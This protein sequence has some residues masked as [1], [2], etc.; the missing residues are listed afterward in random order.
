MKVCHL[1]SVHS[2]MDIRIF[3]KECQSLASEGY[4]VHLVAPNA[5][6]SIVKGINIHGVKNDEKKGR[7]NRMTKTVY[8]VYKKGLEI[9]ADIY[10]FHDPELIPVGIKL[11]KKGKKIIYDIH[12]DLPRAIMS[13]TW[14]KPFIRKFV[15]NIFEIFENKSAKKFDY[16][17]TATPFITKRFEKINNTININNYPLLD[18]L[19]MIEDF[20]KQKKKLN[21]VCYVGGISK[22]RGVNQ[23]LEASEHINGE[24][25][26]AGPISSE[27]IKN[28]MNNLENVRYV[29]ILDR[30]KVRDLLNSSIGGIVTFLPEPNHINAQ[31]NKMFEYMSAGIPVIGSNFPLWKE[32]I[33]RKQCG[34]CVDPM[35][36][37]AI[38][39]A[40]NYLIEHPNKARDMGE[41]ARLAIEEEYNWEAE[42]EKLISLYKKLIN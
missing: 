1:T 13:K 29:G 22:I 4:E 40:I 27:D 16:L 11:K 33:D 7:L 14:V 36:P 42:S 21:A 2:H 15:A 20:S 8:Q 10:H 25:I 24:I 9:D 3:I 19:K 41:N 30:K 31:P 12:E 37:K 38:S 18:E 6:N 17:V 35:N 26:F 5:P 39:D 34:I 28:K 32:I 23:L